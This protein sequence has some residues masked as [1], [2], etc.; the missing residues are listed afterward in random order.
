MKF[1]FCLPTFTFP[2]LDFATAGA[3]RRDTRRR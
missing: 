2:D 1:A 3:A